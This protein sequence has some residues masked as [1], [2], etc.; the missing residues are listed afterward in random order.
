MHKTFSTPT[1]MEDNI[2][3]K[4]IDPIVIQLGVK[5]IAPKPRVTKACQAMSPKKGRGSYKRKGRFES[6][7]KGGW[8]QSPFSLCAC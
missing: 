3:G 8:K 7:W 4:K 5:D 2:M 6:D 1:F